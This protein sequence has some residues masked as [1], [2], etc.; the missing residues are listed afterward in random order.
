MKANLKRLVPA[1][2]RELREAEQRRERQRL[3][4]HVLRLQKF[5]AIGR[6]AGA[7]PDFN[8]LLG[9]ILGQSEIL[10]SQPHDKSTTHGLEMIF[11]S[12]KRGANLSLP[13]AGFRKKACSPAQGAQR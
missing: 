8:N 10:L 1:V 11:E 4:Q 3:E 13:I 6:L 7:S 9:V 2:Q 12:A 5:E